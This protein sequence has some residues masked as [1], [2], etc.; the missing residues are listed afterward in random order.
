MSTTE[1]KRLQKLLKLIANENKFKIIL[2]L[3][4][5]EECV[6]DM[7]EKLDIEQSL[8]SHHLKSLRRAG[9]IND[10]KLGTWVHC[11]LNKNEFAKLFELFYRYLSPENISDKM[12]SL[13]EKCKC[14]T[15]FYERIAQ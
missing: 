5:G 1:T 14:L 15:N 6:C 12:C 2:H 9:L 10:R 8:V 11:S 4:Q 7:G 13:H 3:V